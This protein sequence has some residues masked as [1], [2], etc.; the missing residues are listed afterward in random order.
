MRRKIRENITDAWKVGGAHETFMGR[1]S[2][3]VAVEFLRWLSIPPG[4][5]WL[6]IGTGS[7][8][9]SGLC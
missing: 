9:A 8:R 5:P 4:G 1:W 6:D 3:L 7:W 2:K